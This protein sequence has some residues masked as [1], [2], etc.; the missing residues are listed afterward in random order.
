MKK[1][2]LPKIIIIIA[3]PILV[4]ILAAAAFLS[5][6]YV[7]CNSLIVSANNTVIDDSFDEDETFISKRDYEKLVVVPKEEI[8]ED[9]YIKVKTSNR[10]KLSALN[11]MTIKCKIR[12]DVQ[13]YDAFEKKNEYKGEVSV[14]FAF[15]DFKW[16]V[17]SVQCD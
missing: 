4:L 16:Q 8:N 14:A 15:R 7:K 2:T 3:A 12:A 17:T 1:S 11:R 5:I 13:D 10:I 9:N 6:P